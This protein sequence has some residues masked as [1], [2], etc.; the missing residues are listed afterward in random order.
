MILSIPTKIPQSNF[1]ISHNEGL[2]LIGSCFSQNIGHRL[3]EA[4]FN[5]SS[6]SFGTIYNPIS[7]AENLHR[8]LKV[9]H[10]DGNDIYNYKDEKLVNFSNQ[11]SSHKI[12]ESAFL[13][14]END[15]LA[16]DILALNQSNTII[17]TFGTAWAYEWKET[18]Q[19]VANC[20]KI[21]NTFFSKRLL[22]VAEIV[23]KYDELLNHFKTKNIVFTVSPVRHAKGG[24]HENNL[25]KS[26]LHLAINELMNK[27]ENCSYFPA[28]EIVID[29]LRDYRFYKEDMIHPSDQAINYVWDKFSETYFEPSTLDLVEQIFK[30]KNAAAHKPF[31]YESIGHKQ[32]VAKQTELINKLKQ[33]APYLDF[34]QEIS[35]LNQ[36]N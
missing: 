5:I 14:K 32:F 11:S 24:L 27:Y 21:P 30:I 33:T 35:Q 19:I 29:E 15:K 20:H 22:T 16:A 10:Y 2:F 4:K 7:I 34:E 31:N 13:M 1:K 6:N 3:K 17:L 8:L 26:T 18:S 23:T 36:Q 9:K 28:Y 12:D 25:S